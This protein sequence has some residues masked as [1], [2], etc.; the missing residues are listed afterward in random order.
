MA[1]TKRE[2]VF[3]LNKANKG[4]LYHYRFLN[5]NRIIGSATAVIIAYSPD[6]RFMDHGSFTTTDVI[7]DIVCLPVDG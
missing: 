3:I 6:H 4:F 5:G 2:A 1:A 7:E